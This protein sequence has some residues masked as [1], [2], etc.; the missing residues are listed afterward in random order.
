[1]AFN[2]VVDYVDYVG[3]VFLKLVIKVEVWLLL[4]Y[5]KDRLKE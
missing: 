2:L 5:L 4:I 1:M 3:F